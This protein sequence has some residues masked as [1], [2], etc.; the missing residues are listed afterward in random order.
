MSKVP[1]K[2]VAMRGSGDLPVTFSESSEL[3]ALDGCDVGGDGA[4]LDGGVEHGADLLEVEVVFGAH[5]HL[6]EHVHTILTH[7]LPVYTT[8]PQGHVIEGRP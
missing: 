3:E 6:H 8:D 4:L 1:M 5:V 7:H 2:A